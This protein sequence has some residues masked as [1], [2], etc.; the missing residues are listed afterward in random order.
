MTF[1][2]ISFVLSDLF[3]NLLNTTEMFF[4]RILIC[5]FHTRKN[6]SG[7]LAEAGINVPDTSPVSKD[8]HPAH[9]LCCASKTLSFRPHH[10]QVHNFGTFQWPPNG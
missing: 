9:R 7:T 1:L 10:A 8:P 2:H 5:R 4:Q 6:A 3:K